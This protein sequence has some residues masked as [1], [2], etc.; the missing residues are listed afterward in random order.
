MQS[1]PK[2]IYMK[3]YLYTIVLL[4]FSVFSYAQDP[5]YPVPPTSAG[6]I[7]AAEYFI[8]VDPGFGAA[9]PI[10]ITPTGNISALNA[11]INVSGLSNGIHRLYIR[12]RNAAGRWSLTQVHDFLYDQDIVYQSTPPAALPIVAA[13][14]FIDT[15][16]GVGAC[17]A[18]PLTPGTS[19]QDIA[20]IVNVAGLTNGTHRLYLRTRNQEGGW[21]I[22]QVRDFIVDFDAAYPSAPTAA[23][24]IVAAEYFIDTDPGTGAGTPV[25][26]TPG[27]DLNNISTSINTAGLALGTHRLYLRTRNQEGSWSI[28]QVRDFIVDADPEYPSAPPTAQNIIAAEYFIDTDPGAGAGT[29]INITPATDISNLTV[30]ANTAGLSL[31]T[32]RIYIRVRNSE[33]SWSIVQ[34][35]D[36]I[37]NEDISYPATPAAAQ[38]IVAAEYFIDTDPGQGAGTAITVTPGTDLTNIS[39]SIN[40]SGLPNGSHRLYLRTRNQEGSW[41]ITASAEFYTD[42]VALSSD[43]LHY[44]NVPENT[45]SE[46]EL[47]VTNNSATDQTIQTITIGGVFSTVR[48]APIVIPA[49]SSDTIRIRFQPNASGTFTDSIVLTT[50]AGRYSAVLQGTGIAATASWSIEPAGGHQFGNIATGSNATFNFTVRNTGNLPVVFGNVSFSDPVF[51]SN[52]STGTTIPANGTMVLPVTFTPGTVGNFTAQLKITST[53]NGVDSV[54]TVVTGNGYTPG[55]PPSLQYLNNAFYNNTGVSPAVGQTGNFTYRILYQ[56]PNNLAPQQGFPR[57]GIDLNGDQDFNDLNEGVFNMVKE[58][59]STDYTTGVVYTYTFTHPLNTSTAGYKFFAADANGNTF[60]TAYKTGPVVTD[61]T[62]DLRIFANNISFSKNNPA[63]GDVFTVTATVL[64][65]TAVPV[66]NVPISFYRDTI[67]IGNGTI[68]AIG[69][70]SSATIT[71]TFSFPADGFYPIK[72]WI[73]SSNTLGES[74]ILNNYAI[75]PVTVGMPA[76]PGGIIVTT[77]ASLQQCPQLKALITGTATYDGFGSNIPVAGAEVSIFYGTDT[78]YTTTNASG[79]F[80]FLHSG[81]TCGGNFSYY[82][83]VTDFTFTSAPKYYSVAVPCPTTNPCVQPPSNGGISAAVGSSNP[84]SNV[85][86]S[87]AS[88]TFTVKYR[89]RDLNNMWCLFDEIKN[90]VLRVYINDILVET[91]TS[92]DN[93]HGPGDVRI[94][95]Y[96]VPLSS[97][98][99]VTVRGELSYTYV[100]YRQIP[101]SLYKGVNIQMSASGGGTINAQPNLPDLTIQNF[102]QTKFTSFSFSNANI[103]CGPAD[104]HVVRIYDSIPGGSSTLMQTTN[105]SSLAGGSSTTIQYSDPNMTPGTHILKIVTDEPGAITETEENNNVFLA[106]VVV[107]QPDLTVVALTPTTSGLSIGSSVTFQAR[108]RNTGIATGAFKVGFEVNGTP[109]GAK[110]SAS[111][112]GE[113]AFI[114]IQSDAYTVTNSDKDCGVTVTA[115]A[116]VDLQVTESS[117]SNNTRQIVLG[118]ELQPYQLPQEIGSASNPAVIRV[119]TPGTFFA[120]IRNTGTRDVSNVTV[121]FTLNGNRID[122]DEIAIVKAGEPFAGYASFTQTFS[123]PGNYVV[124]VEADTSNTVCEDNETNNSGSFHIRVVD[125][126]QDFEVLSQYI[127]PSSLNPAPGQNITIVGTVRNLGGK[128]S[129]ATVLRFLVDD[130]QLG[131]DVPVGILQPGKDTTVAATATYSSLVSNVKVMKLIADPANTADEEREDNN[132]ATRTMIVGDAPDLGRKTAGAISF[133]PYGFRSGDSVTVSWLIRNFGTQSGS[134]WV[135]FMVYDEGDAL[136]AI[137]SIQVSLAAQTEITVSRKLLFDTEKGMVV[138]EIV[139]CSPVEFD[140]T[141]NKDTLRFSTTMNLRSNLSV[142]GDLDMQNGLPQQLPGWIGGKLVLGDYDLVVNGNILNFDTSHFVV[143]NGAGKLKIMNSSNEN[144]FP[145]GATTL[146][147]NF[148]KIANSGTPDQFSV[149]VRPYVLRNGMSGDTVRTEVV[150]RTWLIEETT[151]GGSNVTLSFYWNTD[152]ETP[153]FDRNQSR[154]A[155]FSNGWQYGTPGAPSTDPE[156]R[157]IKTQAGFTGFSPFTVTSSTSAL[158]LTL[159]RFTATERN[160]AALL[161]WNTSDEIQTSHFV[162]EYGRNGNTFDS[163]GRVSALNIP[164]NNAYRFRHE[165]S[166]NGKHYYRLKMVDKDG[167]FTYSSTRWIA[168]GTAA[169]SLY[170]NPAQHFITIIGVEANGTIRIY[171]MDG[172]LL[173]QRRTGGSVEKIPVS[174][175]ANGTYIVEFEGRDGSKQKQL[176]LKQ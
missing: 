24:N 85:V 168:P 141:N 30:T 18:I 114:T 29:A 40:T 157:W 26:I 55:A 52:A 162:I 153:V 164:G 165:P 117:E 53:T 35:K 68:S 122:G 127:S 2:P 149:A 86:G 63:P 13:E 41:S 139:R 137:D 71:H 126:K 90:D 11:G 54:T 22:T 62:T 167:S 121:R 39:T 17:T 175:L 6:N 4:V 1:R 145:V 51:T 70:N 106:T 148:V 111:G 93:S 96:S 91:I 57:L 129:E 15:D 104:A 67:L 56:H 150:N 83:Q 23:Q 99:P 100:E 19:L 128:P 7:T 152:H 37:V 16:P 92:A 14:Y 36:F 5:E 101:S 25:L 49:Q 142:S 77:S 64:N 38:N 132:M 75:R 3:K 176:L 102:A 45:I 89:E 116:D 120:A 110:V 58:G 33:G 44:T 130:V 124:M 73:D 79:Q 94:I 9:T 143:T 123:M 98:T 34:V 42:L 21:S 28:T 20:V 65:S 115:F 159:L 27:T 88:V 134:A 146:S 46:Q 172:K 95:P 108:I 113:E 171:S 81:I 97:T 166:G 161:E 155:H 107:P 133:N 87:T 10:T 112:I 131:T 59:S 147:S 61:E 78:F 118:A 144:I 173:Q 50:T 154:T 8:D 82:A 60:E 169:F 170:P 109:L 103:K 140:L 163:A 47:I 125:S 136:S 12:V 160:G 135:K 80:S 66:T 74:N 138:T 72:V 174:Q 31:G 84:C 48:S 32:H 76:L 156:T 158:P 69:G 105:V 43:T 151:P 119:N